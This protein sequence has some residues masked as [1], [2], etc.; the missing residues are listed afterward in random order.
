VSAVHTHVY[1]ACGLGTDNPN[2]QIDAYI[3]HILELCPPNIRQSLYEYSLL[4]L[5]VQVVK[6]AG[7]L[8]QMVCTR[9]THL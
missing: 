1:D 4:T 9:V 2:E 5:D 7:E 6:C 8:L 3:E